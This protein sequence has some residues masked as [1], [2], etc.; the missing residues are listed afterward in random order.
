MAVSF[1]LFDG[2]L[3]W[4]KALDKEEVKAVYESNPDTNAYDDADKQSVADLLSA[5]EQLEEDLLN[6][7]GSSNDTSISIPL[8]PYGVNSFVYSDQALLGRYFPYKFYLN[9]LIL[10]LET[11]PTGSAFE[12]DIKRNGLSIFTTRLTVDGGENTSITATVPYALISPQVIFSQ[13]DLITV[14]VT[15]VG[16]TVPGRYPVLTMEGV[17]GSNNSLV[18]PLSPLGVNATLETDLALLGQYFP[19]DFLIED[20]VL[21]LSDAPTGSSFVVDIKKNGVSIFSTL[22]S[23]DATE[24]TSTTAAV[25]YVL[26]ATTFAKGDLITFD[27]TQI[28]ATLPG[29]YPVIAIIGRDI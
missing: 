15:Q 18:V 1:D 27:V 22:L 4:E 6:L 23:V 13:G 25:P 3:V 8:S 28:G 24:L 17:R 20:V 7:Y 14:D 19:Y 26:S 16:A 9:N 10:T 5:T 11:A 29:R 21:T 12:I 2:K